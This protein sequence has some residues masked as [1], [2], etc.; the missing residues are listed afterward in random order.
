M[1]RW[2]SSH[3]NKHYKQ[4]WYSFLRNIWWRYHLVWYDRWIEL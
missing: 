1:G 4:D 3:C 2:H